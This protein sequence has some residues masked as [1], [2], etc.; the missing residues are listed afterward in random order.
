MPDEPEVVTPEPVVEEEYDA[1]WVDSKPQIEEAPPPPPAP[2]PSYTPP[3]EP[4]YTGEELF[5]KP[6]EMIDKHLASRLQPFAQA[7]LDSLSR[8]DKAEQRL[9]EPPKPHKAMVDRAY[10]DVAKSVR[11]TI[12][13]WKASDPAFG[14]KK[15]RGRV[16]A[17]LKTSLSEGY[18]TAL[19]GKFDDLESLKNRN[20]LAAM[21]EY[22]KA[23]AGYKG[24]EHV[25]V[26]GANLQGAKPRQ[27]SKARPDIDADT[28]EALKKTGVS[29][30]AYLKELEESEKWNRR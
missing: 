15:V 6:S 25:E 26:P 22:V 11:E 8:L 1:T 18:K 10:D 7:I 16:E 24:K 2:A 23:E 12:D 29:P 27:S 21:F 9:S 28:L 30:D 13:H 17:F 4:K 14:D 20:L 3:W 5:E 19:T